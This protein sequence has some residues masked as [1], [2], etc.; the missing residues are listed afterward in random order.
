MVDMRQLSLLSGED[1]PFD[2]TP[3]QKL[4]RI[5]AIFR[6]AAQPLPRLLCYC[7]LA[8]VDTD[9]EPGSWGTLTYA[10]CPD[11]QG[12][13]FHP[14]GTVEIKGKQVSTFVFTCPHHGEKVPKDVTNVTQIG[15]YGPKL[16]PKKSKRS[17]HVLYPME[18]EVIDAKA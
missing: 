13:T 3:E 17:G 4:T 9:S 16:Y 7:C 12:A 8:P 6:L 14:L 2:E 15:E 18:W 1:D 10:L 11:C 5:Q